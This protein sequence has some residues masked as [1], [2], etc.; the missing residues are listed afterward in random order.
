M[1]E[2]E[3]KAPHFSKDKDET[4]TA[5]DSLLPRSLIKLELYSNGYFL[6]DEDFRDYKSPSSREI[7]TLIKKGRVPPHIR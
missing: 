7:L 2:E 5:S 4:E 3:K 6:D 1:Q